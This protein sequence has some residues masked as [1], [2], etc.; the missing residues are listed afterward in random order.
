MLEDK[1][2]EEE[3][4]EETN[5]LENIKDIKHDNEL[6]DELKEWEVES[7]ESGD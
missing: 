5:K 2:E 1:K 7:T 3:D 6:Q 4:K